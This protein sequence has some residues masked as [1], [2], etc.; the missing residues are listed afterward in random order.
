MSTATD[1]DVSTWTRGLEDIVP[2]CEIV[3]D[4]DQ[5]AA[6][7]YVLTHDDGGQCGAWL[8]C[9][10]HHDQIVAEE[11]RM[12]REYDVVVIT[13]KEHEQACDPSWRAL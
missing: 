13:C 8:C 3:D 12:R 6:W 10:P 1:V 5:P 4:C 7:V 2:A 9:T 11:A